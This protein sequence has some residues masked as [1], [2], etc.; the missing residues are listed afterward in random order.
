MGGEG[1]V[2][3]SLLQPAGGRTHGQAF[4]LGRQ[5]D[6]RFIRVNCGPVH[7]GEPRLQFIRVNSGFRFIR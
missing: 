5:V 2:A 6:M 3:G 1:E 4:W 7:P